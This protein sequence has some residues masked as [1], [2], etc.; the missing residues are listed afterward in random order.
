MK[1]TIIAAV[2]ASAIGLAGF[3]ATAQTP[4]P[5]REFRS[6][7]VAGMGID[8]PKNTT[9][10]AK[11][12]QQLITYLDNFQRQNF[13]GVCI[14]VRPRADAYYKSSYEPWSADI[15]G[16]R[17]KDPGWD[18]LAFA[19]EECHKRGLECYAW[20]NPYRV[21]ANGHDYA[22]DSR[23]TTPQDKEWAEKGWLIKSGNWTS[24]N[25][26]LPEAR[27]HCLNVIK[28]IYTN[29]AIDGML[30]DDYF[31]PG[32][33]MADD[34]SAPDYELWQN[35]GTELSLPDWR[36]K[37]T[38]T[39]VQTLYDDIQ[40]TRPDMRFGIGPA[41]V[42][43]KSAS[44][45]GLPKPTSG[46][47]WQY[48]KIYADPLAWLADGSIDFISPQIYWARSNSVARYD[49][50][51][52]WW[53]MVADH[54]NRHNYV[55]IASYKVETDEFSKGDKKTGWAEIGAQVDL[56]RTD[57][58]N[59]A[60]GVIYYNTQ[61][62]N[63]P[64]LTGLGD[65][66]GEN[67]Y[68]HKT[69]VPK[70]DWKEHPVYEAVRNLNFDGTELTWTPV[71]GASEKSIIRYSV[72]AVPMTHDNESA[73]SKDGDGIDGAYLAGVS[74]SP[75]FTVPADK[76]ADHWFAV[77]V[78]DG[79]G[80]ESQPAVCS[81]SN[82][83]ADAPTLTSPADGVTAAWDQTFTWTAV[84][85]AS[86]NFQIARD[87]A[88][89]KIEVMQRGLGETTITVDLE[90]FEPG[91]TLYWRAVANVSGKLSGYS[92]A[93]SIIVPQPVPAQKAVL[94]TPADASDN[95]SAKINFTWDKIT[96]RY[97]KSLRFELIADGGTF[98]SPLIARDLATD[99]TSTEIESIALT[100]GK[101]SWRVVTDGIRVSRTESDVWSFT[102]SPAP[103]G[104]YES[105]YTVRKDAA[106]Y[107]LPDQLTFESLWHRSAHQPFGN[108]TFDEGSNG[109]FNRGMVATER[110]VFV[111]GRSAA[112]SSADIYLD[113][114]DALTGEHLRRISLGE[115]GK[116][117][118]L[119]C[120]DVLRDSRGNILIANLSLDI[121]TTPVILHKVNLLD[122]SLTQVA[123]LTAGSLEGVR[124]DHVGVQGDVDSGSFKVWAATS[125]N[126]KLVQWVVS[127]PSTATSTVR[128]ISKFY[129]SSAG[130]FGTAPRV[131]PEGGNNAV[132]VDGGSTAWTLYTW[133]RTAA[134]AGSFD[135][136][137]ACAPADAAD[138]GG[139]WFTMGE[140]S[141][142][143]Y[144]TAS[145]QSGSRFALVSAEKRDFSD[146][147]ALCVFPEGT[148][149]NVV[150]STC[151]SPVDAVVVSPSMTRV[152]VY[153]PGNGLGAYVLN[154]ASASVGGI[155]ADGEGLSYTVIG[156]E[157]VLNGEAE[158][159]E[160][161]NA[162]GVLIDSL[163]GVSSVRLPAAG[164]YILRADG[165]TAKVLVR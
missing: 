158:K 140:K 156:L 30:F 138:N 31:Y 19:I 106:A 42:A 99:A 18:P 80:Y 21:N 164:L 136:A 100:N 152:Y 139:A 23:F 14:H 147:S 117:R 20:V 9:S 67:K 116:V 62:M 112:S 143:V 26:G 50:L 5:K 58:R 83:R 36:R 47:D 10:E 95:T 134:M 59:N 56:T 69:L 153:S 124:I 161:Y 119:P 71:K 129:P 90:N 94:R 53:S 22:T 103:L 24:F 88:F 101:Y 125:N 48:D 149:G 87:A 74:Y 155:G 15:S 102:V 107:S 28:E 60:P 120:N 76:R 162:G 7:W 44:K 151:S 110:F 86:Y 81:Y 89:D 163:S 130:N 96:D 79:F 132:F 32:D 33:G 91:T 78:Y 52:E 17:G 157:V 133:G 68:T 98:E 141:Y 61:S 49:V 165:L 135:K 109:S 118:Y 2:I 55:S 57:T 8:W 137:P 144:T 13:T 25:P 73:R 115:E 84:E 105:G 1:K 85:G 108:M 111:S 45:Y 27:E 46:S 66:L 43:Y 63:G 150:S 11:A 122:G 29:Y 126:N 128:N 93:R 127:S 72:Y 4:E 37:N 6:T 38:D 54:F 145:S 65:Y 39:F 154:D 64:G 77:C 148:L 160:V 51:C 104:T 41:G 35:S 40:A 159:V 82:E 70:V 146:M 121:A 131:V 3:T 12:K 92:D 114:Y 97:V 16:R 75:S 123:S 142:H 113:Q 34:S